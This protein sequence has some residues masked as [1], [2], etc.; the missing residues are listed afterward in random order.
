MLSS[1]IVHSSPTPQVILRFESAPSG[2][3]F[4]ARRFVTYPFFLTAPFR[5][6]RTPAGMLTTILQSVSGGVYEREQLALSL[7]AGRNAQAHCTTQS[8]TVVHS[9]AP[10]GTA[11][12]LVTI[13]AASGSF[14]EY[15]PDPLILFPDASLRTAL[16][17]EVEDDTMVIFSDGFLSH[18]PDARGRHFRS[19]FSETL[20]QHADGRRLCA[21]RFTIRGDDWRFALSAKPQSYSACGTVWIITSQSH[22]ELRAVLRNRLGSFPGLYAGVSSLP[23]SAGVWCRLLAID[24]AVLNRGLFAAWSAARVVLTRE[25]PQSRRKAAWV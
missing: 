14:V 17:V 19:L 23:Y 16:H 20:V 7:T 15:L 18:D 10:E 25:E 2:E 12:Q 8:A 4:L 22:D 21:D 13:H 5:L 1:D 3:T 9:M 24:A 6:D 11:S